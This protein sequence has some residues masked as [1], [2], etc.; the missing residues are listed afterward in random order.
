MV[1]LSP[2]FIDWL[3]WLTEPSLKDRP[4]SAREALE[5]LEILS[6]RHFPLVVLQPEDSKIKYIKQP[7][8][9]EIIIPPV[10]FSL[11][12]GFLCVFDLIWLSLLTNWT[13]AVW[14]EPWLMLIPLFHWGVGTLQGFKRLLFLQIHEW[15]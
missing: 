10:G 6:Q 14:G 7:E 12:V 13:I 4:T 11:R 5:A 15:D 2:A 8:R 1:N 3:R 9:L